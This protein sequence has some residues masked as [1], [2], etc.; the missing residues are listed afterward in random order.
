MFNLT[1]NQIGYFSQVYRKNYTCHSSLKL[2][3]KMYMSTNK[4][5]LLINFPNTL[6]VF[7]LMFVEYLWL[8]F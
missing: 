8:F 3:V 1:Y 6:H 2:V 7:L 5:G 4:K